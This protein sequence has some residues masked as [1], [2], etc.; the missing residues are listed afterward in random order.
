[1]TMS[2]H[3]A[4]VEAILFVAEEPVTVEELAELLEV[5]RQKRKNCSCWLEARRPRH[6]V[7]PGGQGMAHL[8]P[9]GAAAYLERFWC[10][11]PGCRLRRSRSWP[12]SP[13][14]SR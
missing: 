14:G 9:T 11:P 1:M 3:R 12:W 2:R 13:T 7:A 6:R 4:Q 8:H 5:S 10:R